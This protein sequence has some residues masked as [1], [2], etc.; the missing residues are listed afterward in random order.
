MRGPDFRFAWVDAYYGHTSLIPHLLREKTD[1]GNGE[2]RMDSDTLKSVFS[3]AT[4]DLIHS[5]QQQK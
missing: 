4:Q 3:I 1:G 2:V 5:K